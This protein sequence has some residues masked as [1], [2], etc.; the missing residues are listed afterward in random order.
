MPTVQLYTP[1]T[2]GLNRRLGDDS[3]SFGGEVGLSALPHSRIP[4][5]LLTD[6]H[7]QKIDEKRQTMIFY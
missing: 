4:F 1:R 7:I 6:Y 2:S 5:L 3:S